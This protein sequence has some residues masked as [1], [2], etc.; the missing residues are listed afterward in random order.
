MTEKF[1]TWIEEALLKNREYSDKHGEFSSD[2]L[3]DLFEKIEKWSRTYL[4]KIRPLGK[5]EEIFDELMS[6]MK[7]DVFAWLKDDKSLLQR[8]KMYPFNKCG[9]RYGA[10]RN[11][12]F[13][14]IMSYLNSAEYNLRK[15]RKFVSKFEST[16]M[17]FKKAVPTVPI[18]EE[19][20]HPNLRIE[21]PEDVA[22]KKETE[23]EFEKLMDEGDLNLE[24]AHQRDLVM[25]NY[26]NKNE[27]KLWNYIRTIEPDNPLITLM[28]IIGEREFH[29]LLHFLEGQT[30]KIPSLEERQESELALCLYDAVRKARA[31]GWTVKMGPGQP[32]EDKQEIALGKLVERV[33]KKLEI[34]IDKRNA[35][36]LYKRGKELVEKEYETVDYDENNEI[37]ISKITSVLNRV[38]N[39]RKKLEIYKRLHKDKYNK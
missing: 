37:G 27:P 30:V 9:E 33:A 17:P 25:M 31:A 1:G 32:S 2:L 26:A 19:P 35:K 22:I 13:K 18:E 20:F 11:P 29:F 34:E 28:S 8:R 39:W 38:W 3:K 15:Q 16:R 24:S 7:T 14:E 10:N 4:S 6:Q 5:Y 23:E 12:H 21:S 36:Q